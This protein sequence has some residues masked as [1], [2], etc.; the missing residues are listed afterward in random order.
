LN[1][2]KDIKAPKLFQTIASQRRAEIPSSITIP[3]S[4]DSSVNEKRKP[5]KC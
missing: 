1:T 5:V 3:I 2:N 4:A